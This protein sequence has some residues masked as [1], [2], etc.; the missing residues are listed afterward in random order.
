MPETTIDPVQNE[1]DS[2]SVSRETFS[3]QIEK[4]VLMSEG[5]LSFMDAAIGVADFHGID[6]EDV[7]K[8][9]TPQVKSRIETEA[10]EVRMI[11]QSVR[12][13]ASLESFL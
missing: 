7:G 13:G 6:L 8:L 12:P 11:H 1:I 3:K 5:A 9:I 10:L 4:I 2:K